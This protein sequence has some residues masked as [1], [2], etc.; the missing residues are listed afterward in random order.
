MARVGN[1]GAE[2]YLL[3]SL[4]RIAKN[5]IDYSVLYVNV[6]KLKAKN[7]HPEFVN[8][9]ARMFDDLVGATNGMMFI[10][11]N[12]D[13]AI[14]GK[15]INQYT[16]QNAVAKLQKSLANDPMLYNVGEDGSTFADLYRFPAD[17]PKLYSKIKDLQE[18]YQPE[19]DIELMRRPLEASQVDDVVERLNSIDLTELV[20]RQSVLKVGGAKKFETLFEEFF[21][22]VKDLKLYFDYSVDL[23]AN[24]WIF[25]YLSQVLDKKTIASFKFSEIK[26]L[27]PYISI[28]LN[29]STLSSPEFEEFV[30]HVLPAEQKLIVELQPMDVFNNLPRYFEV[31][32][33]LHQ[34]GYLVLFDATDPDM[35][36]MINLKRLEPDYVKIFWNQIYEEDGDNHKLRELINDFGADKFILSKCLND[37][38]LNWGLK[39]H[40]RNF[41]GP[42]IDGIETALIKTQCPHGAKC[43]VVDCLKRRRVIAGEARTRCF[44]KNCLDKILG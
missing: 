22:A 14:L 6:S 31:K 30:T 3:D 2:R 19:F 29:M 35:L 28:N 16:V 38:A 4:N 40:I 41:Q 11:S 27:P 7:R 33:F 20:K 8:I 32:N 37:K 34:K 43:K 10:L 12:S 26:T 17:F 25:M 18:N 9:F 42:F 1:Q 5:P 21:V 36:K 39:Y 13:F 24:K 23:Q 15:N 44:D